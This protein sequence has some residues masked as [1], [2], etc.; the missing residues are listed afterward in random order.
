MHNIG[1]VEI[2]KKAFHQVTTEQVE[3]GYFEFGVFEGSSLYAAVH[4]HKEISS[5]KSEKFYTKKFARHFYGFDS[6]DQGFKYLDENDKHPFFKEGDFT[7]S[8][9]KCKKRF[10]NHPHVKLIPGYFEE[11]VGGKSAAEMFP[12]GKCAILFI[13]CD[14][15][16]PAYVVLDFMK[17][18]L[19]KGTIIILD[20]YYA[21]NAD[22]E[23]GTA[24][25]LAR[26]LRENPS[27]LVREFFEYG[28][29]GK[30]FVVYSV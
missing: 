15:T 2:I 24:G 11:S 13:D 20:D 30:S 25:A 8:Y 7:S 23:K 29:N 3:G 5:K 10:K 1:K 12:E 27:I 18:S 4:A 22:P 28:Y 17:S 19:Q 9:G 6:F 14:L 16:N 21:Y 26:F